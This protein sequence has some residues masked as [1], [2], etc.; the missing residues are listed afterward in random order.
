MNTG[1]HC[2]QEAHII[3]P[4]WSLINLFSYNDEKIFDESPFIIENYREYIKTIH[5]DLNLLL[6]QDNFFKRPWFSS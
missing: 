5:E 4:I 2:E 3:T 6:K 1:L